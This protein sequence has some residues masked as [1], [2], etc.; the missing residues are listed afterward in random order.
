MKQVVSSGA[1][2]RALFVILH[3][4]G[5]MANEIEKWR[6]LPT[7]TRKPL[8]MFRRPFNTPCFSAR[9]GIKRFPENKVPPA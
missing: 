5:K 6:G 1:C 2:F 7:F 8:N 4:G 9:F 3:D